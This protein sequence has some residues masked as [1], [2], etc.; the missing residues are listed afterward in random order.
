M[1]KIVS[2]FVGV[3]LASLVLFAT[4]AGAWSKVVGLKNAQLDQYTA[5]LGAGGAAGKLEIGPT[6]MASTCV[7]VTLNYPAAAAAS[8]GTL[9]LSGFP[10]TATA[11]GNCTAGE[12]RFRDS[13]NADV[14]TG[15]TVTATGG[16]G[17]ITLDNPSIVTG[18]S[19]TINSFTFTAGN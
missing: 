13:A 15:L 6:G 10:K 17:N 8:G 7:T 16:G 4:D 19:V 5:K 3:V 9:P 18:Q 14:V 12:A 1:K 2:I 11:S